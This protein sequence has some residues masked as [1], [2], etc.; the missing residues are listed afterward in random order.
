M[1]GYIPA[2][3]GTFTVAD[4]LVVVIPPYVS[5]NDD[6]VPEAVNPELNMNC[7]GLSTA[8]TV[9]PTGIFVPLTGVPTAKPLV[10]A[11]VTNP[12][13]FVVVIPPTV[14]VATVAAG[15]ANDAFPFNVIVV[16]EIPVTVLPKNAEPTSNPAG[17]LATVTVG[18]DKLLD[19]TDAVVASGWAYVIT[20]LVYIVPE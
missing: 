15:T 2:V 1:P 9:A 14:D 13:R 5:V 6:P 19:V 20:P 8:P 10:L 16:P 18:L 17:T 3:L 11:T 4:A 12:L 7:V